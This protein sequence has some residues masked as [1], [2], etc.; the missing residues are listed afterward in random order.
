VLRNTQRYVMLYYNK[1]ATRTRHTL[2]TDVVTSGKFLLWYPPDSYVGKPIARIYIYIYILYT[3]IPTIIIHPCVPANNYYDIA[4]MIWYMYNNTLWQIYYYYD[5]V[6][7]RR[8]Y[9]YNTTLRSIKY[10]YIIRKPS[11]VCIYIPTG[12]S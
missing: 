4:T 5:I 3:I 2:W 12:K 10:I 6:Y 11:R 9:L 1:T 7:P 8:V